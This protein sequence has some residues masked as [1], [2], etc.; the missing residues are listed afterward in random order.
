M[1][2]EKTISFTRDELKQLKGATNEWLVHMATL[3]RTYSIKIVDTITVC[4]S[5]HRKVLQALGENIETSKE[6]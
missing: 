5:V 3:E 1:S 2:D 6:R 4:A